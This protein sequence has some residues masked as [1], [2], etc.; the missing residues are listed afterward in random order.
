MSVTLRMQTGHMCWSESSATSIRN[1]AFRCLSTIYDNE[2]RKRLTHDRNKR[3]DSAFS[4]IQPFLG[5]TNDVSETKVLN[6]DQSAHLSITQTQ[7]RV[8]KKSDDLHNEILFVNKTA[9]L[10]TPSESDLDSHEFQSSCIDKLH[11]RVSFVSYIGG[12]R[13]LYPVGFDSITD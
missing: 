1:A 5:T 11:K 6:F 13:F 3:F 7:E 10:P 9:L 8:L 4:E 2:P 12:L